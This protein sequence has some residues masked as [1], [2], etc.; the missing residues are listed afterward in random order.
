MTTGPPDT[1]SVNGVGFADY[2]RAHAGPLVALSLL[3]GADLVE[4]GLTMR[5][6]PSAGWAHDRDPHTPSPPP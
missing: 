4:A 3:R 5:R 1:A 6:L 2:Y